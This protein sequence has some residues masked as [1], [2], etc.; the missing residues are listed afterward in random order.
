[1]TQSLLTPKEAATALGLPMRTL[2][3]WRHKKKGPRFY[4]VGRH[5]RYDKFDVDEYL[6]KSIVTTGSI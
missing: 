4:K 3:F 5:V 6:S 2:T 1:M